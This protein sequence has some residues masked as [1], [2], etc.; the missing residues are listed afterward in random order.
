MRFIT[1]DIIFYLILNL[2][3]HFYYTYVLK[4][5]L[6]K[7]LRKARPNLLS[8]CD[9]NSDPSLS[10]LPFSSKKSTC[11]IIAILCN[12]ATATCCGCLQLPTPTETHDT[13]F[14]NYKN[15]FHRISRSFVGILDRF[16]ALLYRQTLNYSN[17]MYWYERVTW[18]YD[19][20]K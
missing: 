7:F 4:W 15:L 13:S 10:P 6:I 14:P 5:V 3:V 9:S 8:G 12:Q 17:W 16:S 19:R 18:V 20:S 2:H 11:L 1:T